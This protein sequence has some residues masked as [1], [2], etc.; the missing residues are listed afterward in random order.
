MI[1]I[2]GQN[3]WRIFHSRTQNASPKMKRKEDTAHGEGSDQNQL[4]TIKLI[5]DSITKF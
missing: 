1:Q 3:Y 2:K 5:G 4:E